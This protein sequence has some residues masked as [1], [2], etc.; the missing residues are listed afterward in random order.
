MCTETTDIRPL[1][2]DCHGV[3]QSQH[4]IRV[5]LLCRE[6]L[7][8]KQALHDVR[9]GL[10][11]EGYGGGGAS[12]PR[13]DVCAG[14][15]HLLCVST[16]Q[17]MIHLLPLAYTGPGEDSARGTASC[18]GHFFTYCDIEF[19]A[20]SLSIARDWTIVSKQ[21]ISRRQSD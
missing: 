17:V 6:S 16:E 9:C 5:E 1:P 19:V 2:I 20:Y 4:V 21:Y 13:A 18:S 10:D 12:D 11:W 3:C 7:L 14:A 8:Q 15:L